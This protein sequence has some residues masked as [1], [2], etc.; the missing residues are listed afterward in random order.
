[1][2]TAPLPAEPW[3]PM[4]ISPQQRLPAGTALQ[5]QSLVSPSA[6]QIA[7]CTVPLWSALLAAVALP[8]EAIS[9]NTWLGGA[10]VAAAGLVAAQGRAAKGGAGQLPVAEQPAR[11]GDGKSL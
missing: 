8:G 7:F 2:G 11:Q 1:M 3:P 5:G 4:L 6:A 9:R 10:V